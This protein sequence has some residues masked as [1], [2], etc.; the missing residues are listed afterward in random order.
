MKALNVHDRQEI[1]TNLRKTL[2]QTELIPPLP[3][4]A[5]KILVLRNKPDANLE[6]LVPVD[7]HYRKLLKLVDFE[8]L[9][10]PLEKQYSKLECHTKEHLH[11]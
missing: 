5:Q 4:T 3:E 10:R 2:Q 8:E 9:T 1:N 7:H 11:I 6:E